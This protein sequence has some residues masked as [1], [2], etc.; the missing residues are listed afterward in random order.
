MDC[1]TGTA[2]AGTDDA[3]PSRAA[4]AGTAPAGTDARPS[5]GEL[6]ELALFL[7]RGGASKVEVSNYA[8]GGVHFT[9][10]FTAGLPAGAASGW[11]GGRSASSRR[12]SGELAS[13]RCRCGSRA[14]GATTP[15]QGERGRIGSWATTLRNENSCFPEP[16]FSASFFNGRPAEAPR[17]DLDGD[18]F[19]RSMPHAP[20]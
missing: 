8:H 9:A 19:D 17:A 12:A 6:A 10:C 5:L 18:G 11:R 14:Q 13:P 2:P 7:H 1:A 15:P 4:P 16:F 3:R 20:G